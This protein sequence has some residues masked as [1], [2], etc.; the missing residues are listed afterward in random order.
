MWGGSSVCQRSCSMAAT[1][2]AACRACHAASQEPTAAT[3]LMTAAL[4]RVSRITAGGSGRLCSCLI[5]TWNHRRRL[6]QDLAPRPH[7]LIQ[8]T[9]SRRSLKSWGP[10]FKSQIKS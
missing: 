5:D 4:E 6:D 2:R 7:P 1:A 8:E 9:R 3:A 10:G